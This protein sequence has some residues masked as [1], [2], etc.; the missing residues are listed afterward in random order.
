MSPLVVIAWVLG[1]VA[2]LNALF[3]VLFAVRIG[4][5]MASGFSLRRGLRLPVDP[6]SVSI[7]IPA[8]NEDRIIRRCLESMLAQKWDDLE[9]IVVADRCTDDTEAIILELAANDKRLKLIRNE[10][11]PEN[12]AGKCHAVRV[13]AEQ[14]RGELLAFIDADTQASPDLIRAAVAEL[15]RRDLAMLSLLT[16]LTCE[17]WFERTTQPVASMALMGLFPPD[18]VNREGS[19]RAFANGQFM[20]FDRQWYEQIDGHNAVKDDLLEDIAFARRLVHREDG[21]VNILR[22]DGLL[23][24]SMYGDFEAFRRG[25]MRIFLEATN[26]TIK[27]LRKQAARQLVVGWALPAIS[28]AAIIVGLMVVVGDASSQSDVSAA[29][30]VSLWGGVAGLATQFG[31]IAWC[32]AIAKQPLWTVVL[33][34]VGAWHV[35]GLMRWAIRALRQGEAVKWGGREYVLKARG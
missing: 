16:N 22:S 21:R 15:Q 10:D 4:R 33:F 13:G 32:Y 9:I 2:G 27:L 12:W 25:W 28:L 14:A 8:H 23:G 35:F 1:I 11:C 26:R 31:A 3:W 29:G 17:H 20:M 34:P 30:L 5:M 7:V 19:G 24:C 6:K 18:R